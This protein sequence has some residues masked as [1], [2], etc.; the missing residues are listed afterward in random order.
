[1]ALNHQSETNVMKR[2]VISLLSGLMALSFFAAGC[3]GR[4]VSTSELEHNFKGVEPATQD[5]ESN[6]VAAI[7]SGRY[8]DALVFLRKLAHK[9][10]L[11]PDQQQAIRDTIAAVQNRLDE[12]AKKAA[13]DA[14]KSKPH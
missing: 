6:A 10:K 11:S 9:A 3:R 13:A 12:Q 2:F 8:P 5:V 7:K 1:M 14:Q 4:H